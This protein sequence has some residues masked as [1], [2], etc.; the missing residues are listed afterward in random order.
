MIFALIPAGGTSRRM[1]RPKLALPLGERTVLGHVIAALQQA[2]VEHIVV[3]IGPQTPEL[4]PLAE[5][6]GASALVLEEQTPDMRATVLHGLR[7]LEAQ[8]HPHES[9][10]W[11]LVP[12]D[13][14]TLHPNIVRQLLQ[15]YAESGP[16]SI[17]VPT[18]Q[19][20]RGHPVLLSWQHV[21]AIRRLPAH[22]GLNVYLRQCAEVT[23][24]VAVDSANI[25]QDLD[26]PEE[27][28]QLRRSWAGVAAEHP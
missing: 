21:A 19:G 27:Y 6:A 1:G 3:V 26:T 4:M 22:E 24:N 10:T 25:L 13:H 15:A 2:G 28:E 18:F 7:W 11:L 5:A 16:C 12:A 23:R 9:D 14:P 17:V 20:Q 8:F